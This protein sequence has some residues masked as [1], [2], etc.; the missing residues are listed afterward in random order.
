[1]NALLLLK[2]EATVLQFSQKK[3]DYY[4]DLEVKVQIKDNFSGPKVLQ[5]D[6]PRSLL[7]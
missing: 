2:Q 3:G 1:M 7:L 4:F 6:S 5:Y